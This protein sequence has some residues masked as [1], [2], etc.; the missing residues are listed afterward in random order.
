MSGDAVLWVAAVAAVVVLALVR[1]PVTLDFPPRQR[2][3][4]ASAQV[5]GQLRVRS[6]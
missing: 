1:V 3:S 5:T 4:A 2:S 6:G